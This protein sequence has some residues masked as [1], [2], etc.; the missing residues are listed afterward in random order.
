MAQKPPAQLKARQPTGRP[1]REVE[2]LSASAIKLLAV[3]WEWI[4]WLA[5][6]KFHVLA[7]APGTG[8]TTLAMAFA[9]IITRGGRW[10][11]GTQAIRGSVVIWSGEDD[12]AD[13]LVPRLVLA[14]ADLSRV[15]FVSGI[16]QGDERR[17]FDPAQDMVALARQI[18]QV[19]DVRLLI[20]DPVV[21]AVAGDSHKNAETRRGLQPLVDL[22]ASV[23]CA[24]LG[25]THFTKGTAGREPVERITGSLAFGAIARVVLVAAKR[26]DE[27]GT[28]TRVLLRAKSNIGPDT[29]GF[30]Y[31]VV[32][33][34]L[35][36]F[37]GVSNTRIQWGD[38]IDG[39]ARDLLAEPDE[40]D[41][42]GG[43]LTEAKDF[44]RTLLADGSVPAKDVRTDADG[45]GHS[46][47]T[48]RRAQKALGIKPRKL[49]KTEG[50]VWELPSDQS[51]KMIKNHEDAH[52]KTV[53]TFG[54]NDHL[55]TSEDLAEVEL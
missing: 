27:D 13:T 19:G 31:D 54:K 46:W 42:E 52:H 2:L 36:A 3:I 45:A 12:P 32:Q 40:D 51:P 44:L 6:G 39:T 35:A 26:I 1:L 16:R 11:D 34:D 18:E 29:G 43:A 14:G 15:Y 38:Q 25:I 48:V 30:N 53:S 50:W 22:A 33:E 17:A 41:R 28:E 55:G 47:V 49:G 24:V 4:T 21:S 8:K 9:A 20:V 7:G 37:P 23:G 5:S 10:P